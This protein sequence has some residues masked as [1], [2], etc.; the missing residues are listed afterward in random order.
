[1][2]QNMQIGRIGAENIRI[3]RKFRWILSIDDGEE[4]YIYYARTFSRPNLGLN[5]QAIDFLHETHYISGKPKWESVELAIYDI[6]QDSDFFKWLRD[7][8]LIQQEG[9]TGAEELYSMGTTDQ[10]YK[11]NMTLK[12]LDGK[13][14]TLET[15]TLQGCWPTKIDWGSLDYADASATADI[16]LTI[17]Y[18]RAKLIRVIGESP[19][20]Q[21]V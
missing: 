9:G 10:E 6:D 19:V 21:S 3:K 14:E 2:A 1:M 12:L 17:R 7:V 18:D 5:E 13:G 15:W 4:D 16:S 11:K 8:V 20:E